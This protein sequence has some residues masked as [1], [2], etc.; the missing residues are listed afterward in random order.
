MDALDELIEDAVICGEVSAGADINWL[1][2]RHDSRHLIVATAATKQTR[3]QSPAAVAWT[4]EEEEFVR[5]HLGW[6]S[7]E[8]IARRLGRSVNAVHIHWEREMRLPAPTRGDWLPLN[9]VAIALG[10]PCAKTVSKW[11]EKFKLL[12][13]RSLALERKVTAIHRQDLKRFAVNPRNWLYFNP[14]RVTDPY[15][16]A[17]VDRQR[18]RWHD[19]WWSIG[20]VAAYHGVSISA[21]NNNIRKGLIKAVDYGNWWVLR[22]EATRP[23][24]KFFTGKGSAETVPWSDN[25]D[26][27]IILARAV[28]LSLPTVSHLCGWKHHRADARLRRYDPQAIQRLIERTNLPI[29]YNP[30]THTFWADWRVA[31]HRFPFLAKA[32][33]RLR[34]GD[35]LTDGQ[36]QALLGVASSWAQWHADTPARVEYAAK[37]TY[38]SSVKE[39][40]LRNIVEELRGW[41]MEVL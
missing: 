11:V 31:A 24:L 39:E 8:E 37:M 16:K 7:E 23:N 9:Q 22:S 35:R 32:A 2:T 34:K 36:T 13:A 10:I 21:V 1:S 17:L 18:Q 29:Q 3:T 38:R 30:A 20:Q 40:T 33:A 5:T 4:R 28:G 19:E 26:A 27:W 6:L 25:V 41:G 12:P 14:A 15:L